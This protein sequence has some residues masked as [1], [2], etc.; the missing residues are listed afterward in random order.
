MLQKG[1][2]MSD[3][4]KDINVPINDTISRQAAID[5]LTDYWHGIENK[6]K[7]LDGEMAVYCD[8][9]NIIKNLL[10]AQPTQSNA[11]NVLGAISRQAAIDSI[12]RIK[13]NYCETADDQ[14]LLIDKAMAMTELMILPS[15]E[16]ERKWIPCSNPPKHHRDVL[17]RGIEAI[18]NVTVHK[19]MQWDVDTWRPTNY[20]PSIRWD[21]WSEI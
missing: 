5:A 7:T 10:P 4:D 18:G 13:A 14:I 16:P 1:E 6:H 20:A 11:S 19:V 21:E 12:R 17:V 2:P 15:V 3:F 8:C 9:K